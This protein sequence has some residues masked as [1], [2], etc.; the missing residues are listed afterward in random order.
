MRTVRR[1][2]PPRRARQWANTPM[3]TT[4]ISTAGETG[5]AVIDLQAQLEVDLDYNLN[6]VTASAIRLNLYVRTQATVVVGDTMS[7]L[8]GVMWVNDDAIAVGATAVPSP[9]GDSADWMAHGTWAIAADTA[10]AVGFPA[11]NPFPVLSDSQ[12]KQRENHSSLVFVM[13]VVLLS[14]PVTIFLGGR[15]LFLL[16]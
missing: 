12:R 4:T 10:G 15:V 11:T 16:P 7:G 5:K 13:E 2:L 8:W 3:V 9:A 6:N 14:D 1:N